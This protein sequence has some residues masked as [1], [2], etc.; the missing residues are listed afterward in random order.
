MAAAFHGLGNLPERLGNVCYRYELDWGD[1][2]A[3]FA[4]ADVVVEDVFEFG[5]AYQYSMET[6]ACIAQVEG[7]EITLWANCQHPFLVRAEM[8]SVF[9]VPLGRVRII[10]PVPGRRL[11]LEVVHPHGAGH[12]RRSRARPA[13]RCGS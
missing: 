13:A 5:S 11:R 12:D 8:A 1:V 9:G 6:H 7:D 4:E 2:D 10:V 3:A